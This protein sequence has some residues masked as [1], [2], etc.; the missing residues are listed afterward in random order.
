MNN[1]STA[2]PGDARAA[3]AADASAHTVDTTLPLRE[4]TRALGALC[5][6]LEEEHPPVAVVRVVGPGPETSPGTPDAV[7]VQDVNRWE[8][9]VRRFER[10]AVIKCLMVAGSCTGTA[11]DLLL[12]SDYRVAAPDLSL[13]PPR[14]DGRLW[15]GMSLYRLVR[16]AGVT[17]TRRL[18]LRGEPVTAEQALRLGLVDEIT[19][20]QE[21]AARALSARFH[22]TAHEDF[23]VVR[24][25]LLEAPSA[26][27]EEALG[28]HLAA[29]DRELRRRAAARDSAGDPVAA[30][31][32]SGTEAA[33]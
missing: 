16:Q 15:P 12:A 19:D 7:T 4:L 10:T 26:E 13:Q 31:P 3:S 8:R 24:Q 1:H 2:L 27:Y 9:V 17:E 25:L 6:V 32:D 22:G 21:A 11:L 20:D 28:V 29:C 23:A 14:H 18:A 30:L 5:D 33:A